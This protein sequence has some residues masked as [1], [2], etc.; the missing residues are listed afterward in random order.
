[1]ALT[2]INSS[3]VTDFMRNLPEKFPACHKPYVE[4]LANDMYHRAELIIDFNGLQ[5]TID[6]A[7]DPAVLQENQG[8]ADKV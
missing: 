6:P 8:D 4:Q 2:Q 3:I 5:A 1:M 7:Q